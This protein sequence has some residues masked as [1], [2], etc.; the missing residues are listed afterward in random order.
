MQYYRVSQAPKAPVAEKKVEG[1]KGASVSLLDLATG[2]RYQRDHGTKEFIEKEDGTKWYRMKV[3]RA[4]FV[5]NLPKDL[6]LDEAIEFF[7]RAGVIKKDPETRE[8]SI[9]IYKDE[10]TGE[11]TGEAKITY[12]RPESVSLAQSL[13]HEAPIRP[14]YSVLVEEARYKVEPGMVLKGGRK[15]SKKRKAQRNEDSTLQQDLNA[16]YRSGDEDQSTDALDSGDEGVIA[17]DKEEKAVKQVV[18]VRK[19]AESDVNAKSAPIVM[20]KRKQK[21]LYDQ[22]EELGWEEKEQKHVVLKN[23]FTLAEAAGDIAFYDEIREDVLG[24][25]KKCGSVESIKVFE[26]NEEGVIA[27]KFATTSAAEKCIALMHNRPFGHLKVDA[28]FYDGFTNYSVAEKAEDA[29]KRDEGWAAWLEDD[30][31]P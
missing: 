5:K 25:A 17:T 27:I 1:Q 21:K 8:E 22:S 28:S 18:D 15:R 7:S 24:E 20:P 3:G 6:T 13:L 23:M 14:G 10:T 19:V 26:G 29:Q 4:I 2:S 12:F 9:K 30:T 31:A 16:E 11:G